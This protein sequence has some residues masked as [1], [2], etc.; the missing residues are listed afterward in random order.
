MDVED[1]FSSRARMK[2]LKTLTEVGELN[3]SEIARRLGLNYETTS[4]H[5]KVLEEESLIK[6]KVFGRI[7]LYRL[8]EHSA[9]ATAVQ[10]LIEVWERF[11]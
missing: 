7:R 1:V 8:N 9:K 2:I 3:G 5:L 4:K 11:Q 10:S 6:H